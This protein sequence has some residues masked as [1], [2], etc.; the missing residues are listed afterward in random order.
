MAEWMKGDGTHLPV[1]TVAW[2]VVAF[3]PPCRRD[4]VLLASRWAKSWYTYHRSGSIFVYLSDWPVTHHM[5]IESPELP[6]D[7]YPGEPKRIARLREIRR[8]S[9]AKFERFALS[10]DAATTRESER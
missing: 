8:E 5:V 1:D 10:T 3:P 2:I 4:E 7:A 6:T 9:D